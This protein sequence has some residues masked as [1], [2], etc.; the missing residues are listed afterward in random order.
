ME[1][2][3]SRIT[4]AAERDRAVIVPV[5]AAL[6]SSGFKLYSGTKATDFGWPCIINQGKKRC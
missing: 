1:I 3:G 4:G 5:F 2:A 6:R